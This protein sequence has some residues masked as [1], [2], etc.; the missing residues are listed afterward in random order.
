MI[1]T[2]CHSARL[3]L[4]ACALAAAV[5][6]PARAQTTVA[7]VNGQAIS[8][9]TVNVLGS[10]YIASLR[11]K[12]G[13]R[14]TAEMEREAQ[15]AV[16]EQVI[17]AT[18]L[19]QEAERRGITVTEAE[20]DT[21][22]AQ[23]DYFKT[24][25]GTI[26]WVKFSRY[27]AD[28]NSNYL[29]IAANL[30]RLVLAD[31]LTRQIKN[32]LASSIG[33]D[34][35]R[36]A[37]WKYETRRAGQ[38]VLIRP[39]TIRVDRPP[40]EE[41][42]A[43]LYLKKREAFR[44]TDLALTVVA[45]HRGDFARSVEVS[46]EDLAAYYRSHAEDFHDSAGALL[47][48]AAVRDQIRERVT[49]QRIDDLARRA[50]ERAAEQL[51]RGAS[52]KDAAKPGGDV[53]SHSALVGVTPPEPLFP[54]SVLQQAKDMPVGSV[55]GPV[56]LGQGPAVYRVDSRTH[57][58]VPELAALRDT[59]AA[60]IR[61][62][63]GEEFKRRVEKHYHD[64]LSKWM[65]AERFNLAYV[66]VRKLPTDPEPVIAPADVRA[67]YLSHR[68]EFHTD[69]EVRAAHILIAVPQGA[70]AEA[71]ARAKARADS[72]RAALVAGAD[73]AEVAKA[74][75]ADPG[76]APVGGDL[77][78]FG[79]GRM[80]Q[81]F[82]DAAFE[83]P[84]GQVSEPVRSEFGYH[85]IRVIDKRPA[86]TQPL[87]EARP[88]IQLKL[89]AQKQDATLRAR[90]ERI[91]RRAVNAQTLATLATPYGGVRETGPFA[92]GDAVPVVGKLAEVEK[93]LP[94]LKTGA[95]GPA[96][97]RVA[98]G[99]LVYRV[100]QR[101]PPEPLPLSS[102]SAQVAREL[103]RADQQDIAM[104]RAIALRDRVRAGESF[105]NLAGQYGEIQ[106][107]GP[108]KRGE[109]A[110]GIGRMTPAQEDTLAALPVG[111]VTTLTLS[112]GIAV[113]SLTKV[114]PP[115]EADYKQGRDAFALR[116]AD[117]QYTAWLL[118]LR[119]RASVHYFAST[120]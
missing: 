39:D 51:R 119:E 58:V 57:G 77:G 30:R 74:F 38:M 46:S 6:L 5:A 107:V 80:V 75:S 40:T 70:P 104:S 105:F 47:P 102:V 31:K 114:E 53:A 19:V 97:V 55:L 34:S 10:A 56:S 89:A 96:P 85:L 36:A 110:K 98:T 32:E 68:D 111:G 91:L 33:A 118:K 11:Q 60:E 90:A 26:D 9:E 65:S 100:A 67:Y 17:T 81:A 79:R 16:L 18:V 83:L 103:F 63:H 88:A 86:R 72:L 25:S 116:L 1:P 22:V 71:D 14:Y 78:Y 3:L 20:I 106:E 101:L 49:F 66:I 84:V 99:Y 120:P 13:Q 54:D 93:A 12:Y 94:S 7:T 82:E 95:F 24:P 73:F 52:P 64:T 41:E 61:S 108:W 35:L 76:S 92:L 113:I 28:P 4:V 29:P 45:F 37:F 43:R 42:I 21:A 15:R 27:K 23:N 2:A 50:A 112:F 115:S 109:D 87:E 117:E 44:T 59:L 69:E 62:Q 48:F 8:A